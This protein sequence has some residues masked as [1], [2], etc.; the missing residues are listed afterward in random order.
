MAEARKPYR[1]EASGPL[2]GGLDDSR[3]ETALDPNQTPYAINFDYDRGSAKTSQGS[4]PMNRQVVPRSAIRCR[5]DPALSPLYFE[6]GKAVPLRGYGFLPY[7]FEYDI[8][9]R[10]DFE[11]SKLLNTDTYFNRRGRSFEANITVQIPIE[12]E[13]YETETRGTGAPAAGAESAGFTAMSFD[14]GEDE[15]I[16]LH[17]KGGDRTAPMSWA[18]GIVNIGRGT[19][20]FDVPASRV[21]NYALCFIWLDS[22]AWG[23]TDQ[24]RCRYNLTAGQ[25]PTSGAAAQ[26]ATQA[27]R[28]ILIHRYVEP[29]RSYGVS[30]GLS[31]DTGLPGAAA[32][33]TSWASNGSLKVWVTEDG[34]TPQLFSFT[35]TA[36]GTFTGTGLEVIRGPD[37]SLEYFL[38]Y[39]I[40]YSGTDPEFLGL[41]NRFIPWKS[42]AF[43]PTGSDLAA[44]KLG[45]FQMLDVSANTVATIYGA[46]VHTLTAQHVGV[47]TF[48]RMNHRGL[49]VGNTNGGSMLWSS[50]DW[51]GLGAGTGTD[52]NPEALRG[53]KVVTTGDMAVAGMRGARLPITTYAEPGT[54]NLE[55]GAG[56]MAAWGPFN[57]LIQC[58]RWNQRQVD[59]CEV[60]T[61]AAPRAYDSADAVL[62]ARRKLSLRMGI[63]ITDKT[64]PD[65]ANLQR[66]YAC[67]DSGGTV[68]RESVVGGARNGFMCP[69]G[70]GTTDG[71]VRGTKMLF[72]SGEGEAPSIDLSENPVFMREVA[73]MLKGSS[74][75]FAMELS[76]VPLEAYYA[77]Q[78]ATITLPD[79][80]S[81][82]LAGSRPKYVPEIL[83]WDVK[84]PNRSGLKTPP[85][86]LITLT[87]RGALTSTNTVPFK[88][89]M[90]FSVEVAHRTDQENIEPIVPSDLLPAYLDAG[91]LNQTRYG[92]D[93]PWVGKHVT[94]QIGIQSTGTADQ[95]DVYIS[96]SPKD[97]FMPATGDPGNAE[98]AYWTAGGGSYSAGGGG[99][100]YA[101]YFTAARLTVRAKDLARSVF[102]IGRWNCGT[103][104]YCELQ[105]R[106]L[107][108]ELRIY[109]STPSGAL[110]P[111]NG[112]IVALRNGKL[113]GRNC[114]PPRALDDSEIL[115]PLGPGFALANVTDGSVTVTPPGSARFFTA[116]PRDS[117]NA[118][119]ET[120]L[121]VPGD[122][123]DILSEQTVGEE[124]EEF[125]WISGVA[126][127]PPLAFGNAGR[128]LTLLTPFADASRVGASAYSLRCLYYTTF[129][130]D[131]R[132]KLPTLGPGRAFEPGVTTVSDVILS[133]VLWANHAPI[134]GGARLRM[135]WP[136]GR[137]ALRDLL[138]QWVRGLVR[139]RRNPILGLHQHGAKI[140]AAA[141]GGLFEMDDRWR[142]TGPTEQLTKSLYFRGRT[143]ASGVSV[144]LQKD[145]LEIN[146]AQV[147]LFAASATDTYC[148]VYDWWAN[149]DGCGQFQ[150]VLWVG[151]PA[152]NPA[153]IAGTATGEHKVHVILRFNRGR[154]EIVFGSTAAYAGATRPEKGLFIATAST[155]VIP[156]RD[157]HV[158]FYV[159]TRASGTIVQIPKCKIMG[160]FAAVT[161]NARDIDASITQASDWMRASTI[162]N[163]GGGARSLVGVGRDSYRAPMPN[164]PYTASVLGINVMPQRLTGFL[165]SLC[166]RLS[167]ILVTRQNAW[168]GSTTGAEPPDF[169]PHEKLDITIVRET[170]FNVLSDA[171]GDGHK[172][173]EEG[174][175]VYGIIHSHPAIS[176]WHELG[177]SSEMASFADFGQVIYAT[178]GG[179]PARIQNGKGGLAGVQPP[180]TA[181]SFRLDR[182]PLWK[183]NRRS[184]FVD[185][186]N[187]PIEP[188][189]AGAAK[190]VNHFD[191]RGNNY[192]EQVQGAG[193]DVEIEWTKTAAGVFRIM[194]VKGLMRARDVL[195]RRLWWG[196]KA[197]LTAGGFFTDC[198]DGKLAIGWYDTYLKAEVYIATD[199][200]VV[201][202]GEWIYWNVRKRWPQGDVNADGSIN[203]G[204]WENEFWSN[205]KIRRATFTSGRAGTFQVGETVAWTAGGG[206]A[207]TGMVTKVYGASASTLEFIL[208]TGGPTGA[209]SAYTGGTSGATGTTSVAAIRPM[210]DKMVVRRFDLAAPSAVA[211][212]NPIAA[213]ISLVTR[214]CISFTTS[215]TPQPAGTTASGQASLPGVLY[216]AAGNQINAPANVYPFHPDM[217]GMYWQWGTVGG[218]QPLSVGR[219]F[220]MIAI[221]GV[222]VGNGYPSALFVDAG[223]NTNSTFAA[224]A[225][226]EGAI[227]S[228]VALVKSAQFDDSHMPDDAASSVFAFGHPTAGE[229]LSGL[230]PFDGEVDSFG[231]TSIDDIDGQGAQVFEAVDSGLPGAGVNTDPV[232][233]GTDIFDGTDIFAV[234]SGPGRVHFDLWGAGPPHVGTFVS[235][236]GRTYA[237]LVATTFDQ[238]KSTLV[239]NGDA[240]APGPIGSA[241]AGPLTWKYHQAAAVMAGTRFARVAFYDVDQ[242]QVSDP[243]PALTI[244][245]GA[246]DAQNPAGNVRYVLLDLPSSPQS[247][248][249]ELWV[250]LGLAG[251]SSTTLY[252]V[253]VVPDGTRE[254][255]VLMP[256][257]KIATF[258]L[259]EFTNGTPPR[260]NQVSA[261]QSALWYGQLEG[262]PDALVPSKPGFPVAV[263]YQLHDPIPRFSDGFG[264]ELTLMYA[265]DGYLVIAKRSAF[266]G[267]TLDPATGAVII[268]TFST[269]EGCIAFQSAQAVGPRLHLYGD[270]GPLVIRRTGVTN[271]GIP[272]YVSDKI[273]GFVTEEVDRRYAHRIS[274]AVNRQRK[275]YVMAM[276]LVGRPL[277]DVRMAVEYDAGLL[278]TPLDARESAGFR[279]ARYEGP[280]VTC[281]ASVRSPDG[282]PDKLIGG[283]EE[284]LVLWMDAPDTMLHG[285]GETPA[286]VWG[287]SRATCKSVASVRAIQAYEIGAIDSTLD[288][289]CGCI[290][291]YIAADGLERKASVIAGDG[292]YLHFDQIMD[293]GCPEGNRYTLGAQRHQYQ[294]PWMNMSL[295]NYL[296]RLV[297]F[298]LEIPPVGTADDTIEVS[299]YKDFDVDDLRKNWPLLLNEAKKRVLAGN[300]EAKWA[301]ALIATPTLAVAL[302]FEIVQFLWAVE[303]TDHD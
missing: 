72:L 258:P 201:G 113:E 134:T 60:R 291:R 295:P 38:K 264:D 280:N 227:F 116:N 204:N 159:A 256:E 182:F 212:A 43:L 163:P 253:A 81:A 267:V 299:L 259:L 178:N 174:E 278:D 131:I 216:T 177:Q 33:N 87:H 272:V 300:V 68:L 220:K 161:V 160:K 57:V 95:Y 269:G 25:N 179:L 5:P 127:S 194:G 121:Y 236:N 283:T 170:R 69:F 70:L 265:L 143:L 200:P 254:V 248:N 103:L 162:V 186:T 175:D 190:Q 152:T 49:S 268:T 226:T 193:G 26:N 202:A 150:T 135:Y 282:G 58:F 59:I 203:E 52:I 277:T 195:G 224:A 183:P 240:T 231:W 192:L 117:L 104:G 118:V 188:A 32:T 271:L 218:G 74:Q 96:L 287:F 261:A 168:T 45:G 6:T 92:L 12:E 275:Q 263:D 167:Q 154:P 98:M 207:G 169:N 251:G 197:S 136:G 215:A 137:I 47:E 100:T 80:G 286:A 54:F 63:D 79:S 44:L 48:L 10:P 145:R 185:P 219:L 237:G 108:D 155:P 189:A 139:A 217:V 274:A 173:R 144:P 166:G 184:G 53:Y 71:G 165:H 51:T 62:N 129:E 34:A 296:K 141:Q 303:D 302:R 8:G 124:Q 27:Y 90:G 266:A 30:V 29:G 7:A 50:G 247:G 75:G 176:L 37:D 128:D 64:E 199:A 298:D 20:I 105:P 180:Q 213:K 132:D 122:R 235:V 83:S 40:R 85:K 61:W 148:H 36:V 115:Q 234:G 153:G 198:R 279:F 123:H 147:V 223:T 288:G 243:G 133:D 255:G 84:D 210:K 78:D 16:C 292:A 2:T 250:Y 46:G 297:H 23:V 111:T 209:A 229:P 9:G 276:R 24:A 31:L 65:I 172:T 205:G 102:T 290:V 244:K 284:G 82:G 120:Y 289:P 281:L 35:Q 285:A 262:Q 294:T 41:G 233:I 3:P 106:M 15:F 14:E 228:G 239:I 89:P 140:Y 19:D 11:G 17:Q 157:V 211:F 130:D 93:A 164:V 196:R 191:N 206:V 125:Y 101:G 301:K 99:I 109:G 260:C 94:I 245:P 114:L 76:F 22:M 156:G 252:R 293:L 55:V 86:P 142:N 73:N 151:D 249:I 4:I 18:I 221:A 273:L 119:K 214:N 112:G 149:L 110:P 126:V 97:A 21:S 222:A 181:P 242:D 28:A 39:G 146:P 158:R 13:L 107:V 42:A 171:H 77:I 270:Q 56:G 88:F 241:N 238:P 230:A 66:R 232:E 91:G 225:A 246:E 1:I 208:L 257:T 67:D 138:P 187:D